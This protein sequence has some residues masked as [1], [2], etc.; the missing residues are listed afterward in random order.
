MGFLSSECKRCLRSVLAPG[1]LGDT[2]R[3]GWLSDVVAITPEGE[4]HKGTYDGYGGV[5]DFCGP[6][7]EQV[8][9]D[10][11]SVWHR[12]CWELDGSPTS[13]MGPSEQAEDQG[14]FIDAKEYDIP[15]PRLKLK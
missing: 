14:Y 3:F 8:V 5:G 1:V 15:D 7:V 11:S 10:L 13:Y 12:A 9:G 6:D 4:I 2:K